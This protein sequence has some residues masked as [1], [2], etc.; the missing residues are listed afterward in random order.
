M[1][2]GIVRGGKMGILTRVTRNIWR[3]KTSSLIVI[4]TVCL[5]LTLLIVLPPSINERATITQSAV[6]SL[7]DYNNDVASSVTLS[8][9]EIQVEYGID[10][11]PA[12]MLR[13]SGNS[14]PIYLSMLLMNASMY[15]ELVSI[16]DVTTVIPILENTT[17]NR[18]Y[19]IYGVPLGNSSDFKDPSIMPSNI[20]AGRNL[21]I[22]DS[23][24]VVVDDV[25]AKNYSLSV[26][27]SFDVLGRNFTVV[28]IEAWSPAQGNCVTMSLEDA[29]AI[30]NT[31]GQATKYL[32]FADNADNVNS[33]VTRIQSL[34]PKLQISSGALQL[35][36]VSSLQSQLADLTNSAQ[37]TLSSIQST[38]VAEISLAVL[39]VVVTVLFV[40]LFSVRER[41]K[42]IGTLKAMGA[43]EGTILG[44][45]MLEAVLLCLIA[46][47]IAISIS[48][49]VLPALCSVLLP[50]PVEIGPGLAQYPNGTYY[51][52][53]NGVGYSK[54]LI[55]PGHETNVFAASITPQSMLLAVGVA[56]LLGALGSL[57]PAL[58]AARTRPAEAMRYE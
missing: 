48:A 2:A 20:T 45:F 9:T 11:N 35:N 13:T 18:P 52:A 41:T 55:L 38:G 8:A 16:P 39:A 24:V 23:G 58:K 44:Q 53:P 42:E 6:N 30:T 29:W 49:T 19:E 40:M 12:T 54:T 31:T 36:S 7:V 34:D 21:Q 28:G 32:V 27:S 3:K 14:S 47:V 57:Y 43:T 51:L 56:L 17:A 46:V 5:A 25:T 1:V 33:V 4:L 10:F 26:G 37:S 22:G 15:T 50:M